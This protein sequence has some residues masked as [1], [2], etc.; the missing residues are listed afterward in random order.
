MRGLA[1]RA[2]TGKAGRVKAVLILTC[3]ISALLL[4]SCG[5]KDDANEEEQRI[6]MAVEQRVEAMR[7]EMKISE[8]RWHTARIVTFSLL[9]GGSL[10]LLFN[11]VGAGADRRA[12]PSIPDGKGNESQNRRR[13]IDRPYND[14]EDEP[15][16]YPYRR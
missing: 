14:P 9:A 2:K 8:S 6:R 7:S 5:R 11:G 4:P 13:V 12:Y 15:D 3:L 10:I 16:E 1:A